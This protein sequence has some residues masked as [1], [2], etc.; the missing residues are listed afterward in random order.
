LALGASVAVLTLVAL[1]QA[2]FTPEPASS[3]P[4]IEL[5]GGVELSY[6]RFGTGI[7]TLIAVHGSPGSRSDFDAIADSLGS[8]FTVYAFD[9]PGFGESSDWVPDYGY[10]AAADYLAEA[11]ELLG[12]SDVTILGFSWGGGVAI[13]FA[14]SYPDLTSR[15]VLLGAVGVPEGFHTG[16][17]AGEVVRY[18]LAAPILLIYPGS[19]APGLIPFE[20]RFG[21]WRGFLDGDTRENARRLSRVRDPALILHADNDTVVGPS[22][23]RRHHEILSN[24]RLVIYDGG[25]GD[26]YDNRNSLGERLVNEIQR[27]PEGKV[28]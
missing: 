14:A 13:A 11:A 18:A 7:E 9:M 20:E 21:F 15:L 8:A 10:G 17:Y 24:S 26:I 27:T 22:G 28:E 6:R 1:F 2:L 5:S 25:H 23:A 12:L 3:V 4:T 16:S 19:V